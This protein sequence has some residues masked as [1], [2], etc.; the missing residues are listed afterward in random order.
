MNF[1]TPDLLQSEVRQV[2]AATHCQARLSVSCWPL[3][4]DRSRR[5]YSPCRCY[6]N[7]PATAASHNYPR[8]AVLPDHAHPEPDC[9]LPD[10]FFER[11]RDPILQ[12]LNILCIQ[13]PMRSASRDPTRKAMRLLTPPPHRP[14]QASYSPP[15]HSPPALMPSPPPGHTPLA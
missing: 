12:V 4:I 6:P 11:R 5:C 7:Q 9:S 10:A 3:V 8:P 13:T 15:T 14:P 1:W 2:E